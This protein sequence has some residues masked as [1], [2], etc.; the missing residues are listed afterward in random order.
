MKVFY[1]ILRMIKYV[2]HFS[3]AYK[4]GCNQ[5]LLASDGD[6]LQDSVI[7]LETMQLYLEDLVLQ[8][9]KTLESAILRIVRIQISTPII[10]R[11]S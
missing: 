2:I 10:R 8:H 9:T 7:I 5:K 11:N 1:A 6:Q 3:V 4:N